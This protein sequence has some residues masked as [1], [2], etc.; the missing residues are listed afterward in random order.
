MIE[1]LRHFGYQVDRGIAAL[2][3]VFEAGALATGTGV[4]LV[5]LTEEGTLPAH[6]P[7]QLGAVVVLAAAV[8]FRERAR[9]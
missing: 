6:N 3:G 4:V 9:L 5:N 8:A 1:R 2:S 7:A